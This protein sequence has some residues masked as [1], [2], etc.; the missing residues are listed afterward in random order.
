MRRAIYGVRAFSDTSGPAPSNVGIDIG[1]GIGI[2][3]PLGT[4]AA[5]DTNNDPDAALWEE[6]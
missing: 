4:F 6:P 5:A 1:I 2:E 3:T